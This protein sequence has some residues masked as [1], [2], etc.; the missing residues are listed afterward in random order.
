MS[1][2]Q[3]LTWE[4]IEQ[5]ATIKHLK[6][7][8]TRKSRRQRLSPSTWRAYKY[9]LKKLFK[10]TDKTPDLLIEEAQRDPE[11][12]ED[13]LISFKNHCIDQGINENVAINSTHG[14]VRGFFRHNNVNTINWT[15][16]TKTTRM[17]GQID[18]N[19]PLFLREGKK[20]VLNREL[21]TEFQSKLNYRDQLILDCLIST[22][23]DDGDLLKLNVDFVLSQN[24][25]RLYLNNNRQKTLEDI[26]VFFSKIASKKLREYVKKERREAEPNDPLFITTLAERKR[27]F[28]KIHGRKYTNLDELPEGNRLS[29]VTLAINFR[30]AS[31]H[32]GIMLVKQQQ[33]PL[34]PK[35]LRKVFESACTHAGI[36]PDIKDIFMGHKGSQSKTY[37][38]KSREELEFYYDMVEPKITIQIHETDESA[39]LRE[40]LKEFQI[41]KE[42]DFKE[43]S[44]KVE[45]QQ[46]RLDK[47]DK[48]AVLDDEIH[49]ITKEI[50]KVRDKISANIDD[51]E[52]WEK[53]IELTTNRDR[54]YEAREKLVYGE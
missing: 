46:Q 7:Q 28:L 21:L 50:I 20:L 42:N 1:D 22:G 47:I 19:Y 33:S 51:E 3:I 36:D 48:E 45:Q 31:R 25:P 26:H 32:T 37:Q 6:K 49:K 41:T 5:Y 54:L 8:L 53:S 14:P 18:N 30:K 17:I 9:W 23:L 38:G 11:E 52:A 39:E 10:F 29:N 4:Q 24:Q 12:T 35:R 2:Q 15:T 27:V 16:P 40:K 44:Q 13:I 43:L 34:R